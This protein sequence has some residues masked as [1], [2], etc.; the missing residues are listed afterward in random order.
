MMVLSFQD[1]MGGANFQIAGSARHISATNLSSHIPPGSLSKALYS[2]SPDRDIWL[3]SYKEEYDGLVSNNTFD[4]ID[5]SEYKQL[6][7]QHNIKA[8]PSMC[9]FTGKKN[10]WGPRSCQKSDSSTRQL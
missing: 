2:R 5:E 6:C 4:V 7:H 1:G 3:E 8:M 10:Q 9:F